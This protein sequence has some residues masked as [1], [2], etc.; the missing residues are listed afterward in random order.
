[1][2]VQKSFVKNVYKG[3]GVNKVFP[4]TFEWPTAHPEYIK[5]YEKD[6]SG[7]MAAVTDFTVNQSGGAWNVTYP[8]S[9]E[10]IGEDCTL[11]IAREIP[12]L[13]ILNLVNLGPY[14]A[15]D[16]EV[17]FDE[18]VMM[19]QQ[20]NEVL[21]RSVKF[22]IAVDNKFDPTIPLEPGYSFRVNDDGTGFVPQ[23]NAE[24]VLNKT[25]AVYDDTVKVK[26]EAIAETIKIKDDAVALTDGLAA[27]ARNYMY[28]TQNYMLATE[29]YK[30]AGAISA[31]IAERWAQALD[32]PDG[33]AGNR[34]S[35]SW[36]EM[37]MRQAIQAA[38]EANK[39]QA[40]ASEAR[41]YDPE[42]TYEPGQVVMTTDGAT[43]RCVAES[44]GDDPHFSNKWVM[45]SI[46]V[47]DTFE[48]DENGDLMPL[49]SPQT[50]SEFE[51]DDNGDIM[52]AI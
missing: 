46:V 7:A 18:V 34:S 22:S 47:S 2:T 14:F 30:N 31:D 12:L 17:T 6:S 10:A 39:A 49:I 29:G 13:Q 15:E 8:V 38:V 48:L 44:T 52:P 32:S 45:V 41:V 50:S 33:L 19:I 42:V 21:D 25:K 26:D 43:Y 3:N 36:A 51:I 5:L 37:A 40:L 9:G 24:L 4:I 1:M 16:I 20:L 35:K 11:V 28:T 23:E 27:D